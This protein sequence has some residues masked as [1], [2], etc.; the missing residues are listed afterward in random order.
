MTAVDRQ[1]FEVKL[2]KTVSPQVFLAVITF[3][4]AAVVEKAAVEPNMGDDMG[5]TW[6]ND[7]SAGSG[8]YVLNAWDR[9]VSVTLDANPNYWG[10]AGQA[11]SASSI[12]NMPELANLQ[13][14]IETGDADIVQ[15]LGPEQE[16][17]LEGNPDVTLVKVLSTRSLIYL[18]MNATMAPLDNPDVREAIRYA[19]NYDEIIALTGGDAETGAG[20]HSRSA[21]WATPARIP[22]RRT[23]PRPR[24]CW[25]RPV[26]PKARRS[27]CSF[28]P[29]T[30]PG[31]ID[32]PTLAAKIQTDL[33]QV[34]LKLNIQMLQQSRAAQHLSRP[35]WPDG[36]D[37]LGP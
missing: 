28:R 27:S 9:S 14:A 21:S 24:N 32:W 13:A 11:S 17:A 10:A 33:A 5:E 26:S 23:S 7:H 30:R 37:H 31:R 25:P 4:V 15:D 16:A 18:G 2:P 29:T 34:G 19:I 1:T 35:G 12:Q 6:L 20:D 8:P 36:P 22:S 3:T